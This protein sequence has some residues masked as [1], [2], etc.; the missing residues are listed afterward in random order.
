[1]N[2][3][4]WADGNLKTLGDFDAFVVGSRVWTSE[5][6][7][8]QVARLA[9]ALVAMGVAPGDRVL[10]WL[11]NGPELAIA[12]RAVLRAGAITVVA[13][14]DSPRRRVEQLAAETEPASLVTTMARASLPL[15]APTV[16]HRLCALPD[17]DGVPRRPPHGWVDVRHVIVEHAPLAE[18]IQR[19]DEDVATIRYTSGTTGVPRGFVTRHEALAAR[20]RRPRAEASP[21]QPSVR[22]LAVLPMSSGFG[23]GPLSYGLKHACTVHFLDRFDPE[24]FLQAVQRHRIER[25]SIVPAM[26]EALLAVP[27]SS[28]Y[29]LSSLRRVIVGG[30]HV[31]AALIERFARVYGIRLTVQYGLSGI[32]LVSRSSASSPPGS[33]GRVRTGIEAKVV[34]RDGRTLGVGRTGALVL[35][36]QTGAAGELWSLHSPPIPAADSGGWFR[37]GDLAH[38]DPDGAL[39]VVGRTDDLIIQG[40]H[41]IQGQEVAAIISGLPAVRECAVVGVPSEYLGEEAVACVALRSGTR[42]RSMDVIS[43]CRGHLEPRGLPTTVLFVE[44]LPR[45][46][47]GKVRNHDLRAAIQAARAAVRETELVR[48]LSAA[49]T[50]ERPLLLREVIGGLLESVLGDAVASRSGRGTTFVDMGLD[51]LG[52][53]EF[54][55]AVSEAVGRRVP[56]TLTY[57]QPTIDATC[58]F[59]LDLLELRSPGSAIC[60]DVRE[61]LHEGAEELRLEDVLTAAE[62]AAVRRPTAGGD[63]PRDARVVFLTGANGF[64]GR[65]LVEELLQKLPADGRLYCLVRAPSDAWAF[66]RLR[67]AYRSDPSL[68]DL[69][70]RLAAGGRLT[71]LGGDLTRPRF[72]LPEATY[73]RLCEEVDC[74]VH[75]GAVVNHLLEYRQALRAE[76]ARNG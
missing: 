39:Y 49:P 56:T 9:S 73:A 66:D 22:H 17:V 46:E 32:G 10:L 58:D 20:M 41:N 65:F 48:R 70:D 18:P 64:L 61:A 35:R 43:H 14:N 19:S 34:D 74:V 15:A 27:N 6:T 53:V 36:R 8:D 21:G 28:R 75:N 2:V 5:G 55:E 38:F 42:L 67:A 26:C 37:T 33:S 31:S 76:R 13:H 47:A 72:G 59:L 25:T 63:L 30:A 3:M 60:P 68:Q 4:R 44:A 40:G 51:S 62:V 71:V 45:N 23:S 1:M 52:S 50:P 69:F 24:R 57:S 16:R 11:P 29:D 54:A 7:H 12:W